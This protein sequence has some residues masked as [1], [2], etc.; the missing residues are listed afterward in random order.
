[1]KTLI[2]TKSDSNVE[3]NKWEEIDLNQ[4]I[5][6]TNLELPVQFRKYNLS[7]QKDEDILTIPPHYSQENPGEQPSE[8]PIQT[9][10]QKILETTFAFFNIDINSKKNEKQS[11]N[12]N[13]SQYERKKIGTEF[14]KF[15][16]HPS[17]ER[18]FNKDNKKILQK[19]YCLLDVANK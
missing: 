11:S 14:L 5:N 17:T 4:P 9:P 12:K 16:Y 10:P 15:A 7:Q 8:Q 3:N 2:Q 1:M 19:K 13:H 18:I 6:S